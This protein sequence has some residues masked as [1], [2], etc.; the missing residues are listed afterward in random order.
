MNEHRLSMFENRALA[1]IFDHKR[2][3]LGG[4][5]RKLHAGVRWAGHV[6]C[7][8]DEHMYTIF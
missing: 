1:R 7:M 3:G 4:G 8:R 2:M 6:A 5:L